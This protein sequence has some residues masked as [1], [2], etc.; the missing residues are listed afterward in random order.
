MVGEEVVIERIPS[1]DK[2]WRSEGVRGSCVFV[3]E[4]T[5]PAETLL[6][7]FPDYEP[8]ADIGHVPEDRT[9]RSIHVWVDGDLVEP[10][11][12]PRETSGF[13]ITKSYPFADQFW[14]WPVVFAEH[15]TRV[16]RTDYEHA[17][18]ADNGSHWNISYV[19]TTGASWAGPIG[20]AI[21][22]VKSAG[23]I[24]MGRE[25]YR[26]ESGEGTWHQSGE[27]YVWTAENFEP[28]KDISRSFRSP[29]ADIQN[30]AQYWPKWSVDEPDQLHLIFPELRDDPDYW[31]AFVKLMPDSLADARAYTLEGLKNPR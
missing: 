23:M 30:I 16:L 15:Q 22:R 10:W 2:L 7:G 4:N 19:L 24:P 26:C 29:E 1:P 25:G 21:V 8:M 6:V 27:E 3:F 28:T 20:K 11:R 12:A 5:G 14:V 18:S 31:S 13:S 9:L 17:A